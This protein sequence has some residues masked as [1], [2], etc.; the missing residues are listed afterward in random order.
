MDNLDQ[1]IDQVFGLWRKLE[2][3][4]RTHAGRT[5]SQNQ[6]HDL[7]CYELAAYSFNMPEFELAKSILTKDTNGLTCKRARSHFT[8][9]KPLDRTS[10]H[11]AKPSAPVFDPRVE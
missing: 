5:Q 10:V 7:F 8:L 6:T 2:N 3:L 11:D 1:P 4:Q 9:A